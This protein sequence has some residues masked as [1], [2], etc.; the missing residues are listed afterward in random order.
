MSQDQDPRPPPLLDLTSFPPLVPTA[1]IKNNDNNH[2]ARDKS[3]VV[4]S[5]PLWPAVQ[6]RKSHDAI[7]IHNEPLQKQERQPQPQPQL[8]HPV[9]PT[10][11]PRRSK[12]SSPEKLRHVRRE[13]YL[14]LPPYCA[15]EQVHDNDRNV[16]NPA[17]KS[18]RKLGEEGNVV[19]TADSPRS[20]RTSRDAGTMPEIN[21]PAKPHDNDA[22]RDQKCTIDQQMS[23]L[24]GLSTRLRAVTQD[25]TTYP[26]LT[27]TSPGLLSYAAYH[28]GSAREI[29]PPRFSPPTETRC[30]ISPRLSPIRETSDQMATIG[31]SEACSISS[32]FS[33]SISTNDEADSWTYASA[34]PPS[35]ER[36][37]VPAC[38]YLFDPRLPPVDTNMY[39]NGPV[40]QAWSCEHARMIK[41]EL[42]KFH[43]AVYIVDEMAGE[44]TN[45]RMDGLRGVCDELMPGLRWLG[46]VSTL[47]VLF[48]FLW[49]RLMCMTE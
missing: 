25:Q 30:I 36:S 37:T 15:C 16:D 40:P 18:E 32:V 17:Q 31:G 39:F 46:V 47:L 48:P 20:R 35:P 22:F 10:N 38:T 43:L 11:L 6:Y 41:D 24:Q 3:R 28:T 23:A 19:S 26:A 12:S 49:T 5:V 14:R 8:L 21:C 42:T 2:I 34:S 1:N 7:G 27:P 13:P 9:K 29:S 44:D 45:A 33:D 4:S